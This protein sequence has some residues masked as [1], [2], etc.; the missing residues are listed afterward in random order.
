MSV[1]TLFPLTIALQVFVCLLLQ[2]NNWRHFRTACQKPSPRANAE[3]LT[4]FSSGALGRTTLYNAQELHLLVVIRSQRMQV[5]ADSADSDR[6]LVA[7]CD[8]RA[9]VSSTVCIVLAV[10]ASIKAVVVCDC[11]V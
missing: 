7:D 1:R 5:V 9:S 10:V 6:T 2:T 8:H 11:T 3:P 4:T